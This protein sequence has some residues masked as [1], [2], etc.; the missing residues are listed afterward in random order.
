MSKRKSDVAL[1]DPRECEIQ[2][3]RKRCRVLEERVKT[4]KD[5]NNS[6]YNLKKRIGAVLSSLLQERNVVQCIT[7]YCFGEPKFLYFMSD[8]VN[9]RGGWQ[10]ITKGSAHTEREVHQVYND[11][12]LEKLWGDGPKEELLDCDDFDVLDEAMQNEDI[13]NDRMPVLEINYTKS[14]E[15]HSDIDKDLFMKQWREA[16]AEYREENK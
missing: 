9:Y 16:V 4:L 12:M 5:K 3:L 14:G 2:Q 7:N 15:W 8:W 10:N 13:C 11:M 1:E 6:E